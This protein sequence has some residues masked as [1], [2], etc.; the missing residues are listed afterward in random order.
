NLTADLTIVPDMGSD[1][2]EAAV[3]DTGQPAAVFGP[4]IHGHVLADIA[5][6][7]DDEPGRSAAVLDRLRRRSKRGERIDRGV[8]ADGRV[9]GQ[10]DVG[11]QPTAVAD[12]DILSDH[13][14][15][16]DGHVTADL[17]AAF[18]ARS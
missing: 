2:E 1:H 12:H 18:D 14:I 3:A 6:G 11:N 16:A 13:A 15:G 5:A 17:C 4:E 7:P 10:V 8:A 9:A